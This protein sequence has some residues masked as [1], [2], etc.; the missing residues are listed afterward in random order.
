MS[1]GVELNVACNKP[2]RYMLFSQVTTMHAQ[3]YNIKKNKASWGNLQVS[4]GQF[5]LKR[6]MCAE[7]LK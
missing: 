7:A 4:T 1:M 5:P 6:T 3:Q 2:M